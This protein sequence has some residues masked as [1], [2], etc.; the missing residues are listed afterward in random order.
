MKNAKNIAKTLRGSFHLAHPLHRF[1]SKRNNVI[2]SFLNPSYSMSSAFLLQ[3]I[4]SRFP[5][6]RTSMP[7]E[8]SAPII[9]E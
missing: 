8:T 6:F 3:T 1:A 9:D 7:D 2:T 5:H 4:R